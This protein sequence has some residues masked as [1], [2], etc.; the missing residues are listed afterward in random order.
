MFTFEA[1]TKRTSKIKYFLVPTVCSYKKNNQFT[2]YVNRDCRKIC[3]YQKST[4]LYVWFTNISVEFYSRHI[5]TGN[6]QFL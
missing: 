6:S 1:L 4:G 3:G 2:S 5:T